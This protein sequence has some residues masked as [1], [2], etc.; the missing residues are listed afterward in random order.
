LI[1]PGIRIR[2]PYLRAAAPEVLATAR[3]QRG[4]PVETL[5]LLLAEAT[6]GKGMVPVP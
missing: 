6:A 4:D 2:L 1:V 3:F 5:R